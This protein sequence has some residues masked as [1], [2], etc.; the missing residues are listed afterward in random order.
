MAVSGV[1]MPCIH[2]L[3][4]FWHMWFSQ[5]EIADMEA[6]AVAILGTCLILLV[7]LKSG[8]KPPATVPEIAARVRARQHQQIGMKQELMLLK[9][10]LTD[11]LYWLRRA[12]YSR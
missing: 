4:Y 6:L 2:H 5:S 1:N 12:V 3:S 10:D 7:M 11:I 9:Q 8:P